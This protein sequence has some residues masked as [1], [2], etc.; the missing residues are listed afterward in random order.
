MRDE[1]YMSLQECLA[2]RKDCSGIGRI[3]SLKE[4]IDICKSTNQAELLKSLFVVLPDGKN[5]RSSSPPYSGRN[6][7]L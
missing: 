4:I 2:N 7:P 6:P 1:I 5:Y 3:L